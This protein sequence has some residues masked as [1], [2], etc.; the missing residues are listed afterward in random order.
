MSNKIKVINDDQI[1]KVDVSGAFLKKLQSTL[2]FVLGTLSEKEQILALGNVQSGK[3]TNSAENE[4]LTLLSL[5]K[6]IEDKAQSQGLTEEMT[7]E[8]FIEDM[9]K[10]EEDDSNP[11]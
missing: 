1:I 4:L 11:Q 10:N 3:I 5:I 6:D 8:S 9:K 7:Q 2:F